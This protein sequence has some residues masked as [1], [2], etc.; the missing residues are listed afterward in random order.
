[1][2][3]SVKNLENFNKAAR[4]QNGKPPVFFS[5][6]N[7][8]VIMKSTIYNNSNYVINYENKASYPIYE[9]RLKMLENIRSIAADN[10][11]GHLSKS[12]EEK[13]ADEVSM[14]SSNTATNFTGKFSAIE[15]HPPDSFQVLSLP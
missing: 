5:E 10:G 3:L 6:S 1:L 7:P 9:P 13:E 4:A 15:L 12:L 8:N 14:T 11:N 2:L